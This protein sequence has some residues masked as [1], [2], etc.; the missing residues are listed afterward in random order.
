MEERSFLVH[1]SFWIIIVLLL[2]AAWVSGLFIDLTGDSGLYAA[3]S[4]QM[5]ASG[6]WINLKINGHAYDQKPH[7]LF[8]LA[9][10]GIKFFGNNNLAFKLFPFLYGFLGI[11]FT[12]RLGRLVYSHETGLLASV[13]TASSLIYFLY[14]FDI[15]TDTVLQTGVML[16]LW[17][18]TAYFN[19]Q[20]TGHLLTGFAGIGLAMLSKGPVGA[21]IPFLYIVSH[22]I[23]TKNRKELFRLK[24]LAGIA[25][26]IIIISPVL[27][28]LYQNFGLK[29][30]KFYFITNNIGRISGSYAGSNHDLLF[31]LYNLIWALFPWTFFVFQA[32]Y[33]EI[34][35][36]FKTKTSDNWAV[37]ILP[38]LLLML[39]IL[40]IARGKAPNYM[41]I[42]IAPLM[43][44][45]ANQVDK[46]LS[47]IGQRRRIQIMATSLLLFSGIF[48]LFMNTC[49]LPSLYK[50]QGTRQA[51]ELFE[52][53]PHKNKKLYNWETEEY[54][55]YFYGKDEVEEIN[56]WDKAYKALS[57]PET[58][59]YTHQIK[60]DNVLEMNY[61]IDTI[62]TIR[63]RGMNKITLQ[64]LNPSTRE[65][66]LVSNY[67][68][69]TQ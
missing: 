20:K 16:A 4:R 49:Y 32:L 37:T 23:L 41:L 40:S 63:Q 34:R 30:L 44:I 28:H 3:I 48:N 69:K 57:T 12:Y 9:G 1:K 46:K 10:I 33:T 21:V 51:L 61:K 39:V 27:F 14:F 19:S 38:G 8:W 43:L 62:Y 45:T 22:Y 59:I 53:D 50:Y 2:V 68:I 35:G 54:A 64:F 58:W 26:I 17:Q 7:L 47:G 66:S 6:D 56:N 5:V 42:L 15:H 65:K 52:K 55:I 25:V 36:V 60:R 24:W 67:L 11:Y 31:Y 29:G 18:L 13:M